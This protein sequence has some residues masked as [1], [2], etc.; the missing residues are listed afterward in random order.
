MA[1]HKKKKYLPHAHS[2]FSDLPPVFTPRNSG[3][4]QLVKDWPSHDVFFVVGISGSGKSHCALALA[5]QSGLPIKLIRP[6]VEATSRSLG[7]LPGSLDEKLAPYSSPIFSLL[8]KISPSSALKVSTISLAHSRGETFENCIVL[9]DEAQNL[10]CKEIRLLITRVGP[11]CK[12]LF[13]GDPDQSDIRPTQPSFYTDLDWAVDRLDG[14]PG[15]SIVEFLDSEI[16]RH[17]RLSTWIT[18]LEN[19]H[20]NDD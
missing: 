16:L 2:S 3:Q 18:L 14:A 17:P 7:H 4:R 5:L 13:S 10:T 6:P 20:D 9:C 12:L 8:S 1:N 15:I 11:N 19:K